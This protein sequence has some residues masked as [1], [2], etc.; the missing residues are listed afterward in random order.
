VAF[1]IAGTH[2]YVWDARNDAGLPVADGTYTYT[3]SKITESGEVLIGGVQAG[4][5][6]SVK[7]KNN[8]IYVYVNGKEYP[9]ASVIEISQ[10]V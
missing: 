6:E 5:V 8:Q 7:F 9:L 1:S 10:E 4:V 2:A 3:V